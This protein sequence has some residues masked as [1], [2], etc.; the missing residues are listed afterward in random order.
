MLYAITVGGAFVFAAVILA[1]WRI[2]RGPSMLD[3]TMAF[4][5]LASSLVAAVALQVAWFRTPENVLVLV[6]FAMAGFI[7]S[8]TI[9]RFASQEQPDAKRV[10]TQA[11]VEEE[12]ARHRREEELLM[13]LRAEQ[14][15]RRAEAQ[16]TEG[17][18]G[19]H[20]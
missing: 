17:E 8:V 16:D 2:A 1:I 20:E 15:A 9:A 14:A 4:D 19:G 12:E 7:G 13:V 11:E 5:V 6:V 3:R 10:Q 18:G